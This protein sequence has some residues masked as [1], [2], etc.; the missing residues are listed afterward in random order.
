MTLEA[1]SLGEVAV[2]DLGKVAVLMGGTSA[3]RQISL[4]SGNLNS[5]GE[6]VIRRVQI[7]HSL[8]I[9]PRLDELPVNSQPNSIPFPF[10][11]LHV[12]CGFVVSRIFSI[13]AGQPHHTPT[14]STNNQAA[15]IGSHRER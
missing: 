2:H 3:E 7:H 14:P 13:H 8:A 12:L 1:Q 5:N 4:M 11:K 10:I 15:R 6:T 9:D